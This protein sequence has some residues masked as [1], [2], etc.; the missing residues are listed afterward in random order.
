MNYLLFYSGEIPDYI[1]QTLDAIFKVEG[2]SCK[3]YFCGDNELKRSDV[4]FIKINDLNNDYIKEVK[5]LK[6]F[7]NES[8]LLWESSF[9]RIFY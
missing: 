4:E 8:N 5:N 1:N 6:Y 2:E 9:L 3:V 7:E